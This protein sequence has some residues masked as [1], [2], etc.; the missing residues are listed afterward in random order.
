MTDGQ[1]LLA[2]FA[3]FYLLEC[4]W[5][6]HPR[7][8]TAAGSKG[9]G[10]RF[11]KP[12]DRFQIAG[13]APVLLSP[14]PPFP[15]HLHTLPWLLVPRA[16]ALGVVQP[17]GTESAVPWEALQ[18]RVEEHTLY[19][20]VKTSV[21]MPTVAVVRHYEALVGEWKALGPD[22]RREA[23]LKHARETLKAKSVEALCD[24]STKQTRRLR[25][26]GAFLFWWCFG[27]IA[28][29]YRWFGESVQALV[30]FAMLPV[31]TITQAWLF[32]R[33]TRQY[34]VEV[35]YR[36]WKALGMA[37]LPHQAARAADHVSLAQERVPHP[38]AFHEHL[39]KDAFL[40]AARGLW[41]VAR[42]VPGW[43]TAAELPVEA[44]A[45]EKFFR[46]VNLGAA[47]Y[48]PVPGLGVNA[49][50]WC[51]RCHAPFLKADT[52]CMDCG[53]VELQTKA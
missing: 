36:R 47:D 52:S 3:A 10:W 20:D 34:G 19:L 35:P 25:M 27:V 11:L 28:V 45:L 16:G 14:L 49:V 29:I 12:F 31:F 24:Q 53:G 38:L 21:R 22:K 4:L 44:E 39:D 46:H 40:A 6:V 48:D 51:P 26:L 9:S 13:G 42:Y 2:V 18:P 30:V 41:R 23:F 15:T 8:W 50:A 5:L 17:D 32:L 33:V 1:T 43:K 7:A 37:F